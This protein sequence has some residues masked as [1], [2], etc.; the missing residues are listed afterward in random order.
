MPRRLDRV[1]LEVELDHHHRL[2]AHDPAVMARFDRHDLRRLVLHD[3][4]VGILDM[5]FAA[6]QKADVRVHAQVGADSR[7]HV[8]RPPKSH[9]VDH[10]LDARRAGTSHFE[11]DVADVAALGS[12]HLRE[13]RIRCLRPALDCFPACDGL[14]GRLDLLPRGTFFRHVS[15]LSAEGLMLQQRECPPGPW[16]GSRNVLVETL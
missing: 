12:L 5:D 3:A 6:R 14:D 16:S 15:S 2:V 11:L 13:Q 7:L 9:R 1:A 8:D 10:A 4:P